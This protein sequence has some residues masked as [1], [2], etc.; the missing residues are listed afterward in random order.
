MS[1]IVVGL[2]HRTAPVEVLERAAVP[3]D[4]LP[5]ALRSLIALEHV[6][7]AAVLST[8]NRVEVYAHLSRFHA[9][10]DELLTWFSDRVDLA[11]DELLG[12]VVY[13]H[14]D[15]AAAQHLFSVAS[16]LDSLIVGERQIA[17]QVKQTLHHAREE[18]TGRRMLQKL[19]NQALGTSRRVRR[20]TE[21][22]RGVSSMVDLG[23]R[24]ASAPLGGLTD[25]TV[26]VV[27]AGKI[28]SLAAKRLVAAGVSRLL[29]HN[30]TPER[31][32]RLA[33]RVDG[34]AVDHDE[35]AGAVAAA[36]LV[37][38]CAGASSPLIRPRVVER[39]V[40]TTERSRPLVLLDLAMPRNVD[41]SCA[42]VDGAVLVDLEQ[43]RAAAV[44]AV[45]STA[46][47]EARAIIEEEVGRFRSWGQAVKVDPTIRALRQR[48]EAVRAEEIERLASRLRHLDE[49][50]RETVEALTRGILNTL[51]HDPTVRLKSL[52][53]A[54]GAEHYAIALRELFDLDE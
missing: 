53:D 44:E 13:A 46:L 10:L 36:D 30:R 5:K 19:F 47:A 52:A 34:E 37:I 38:C 43:V 9:G 54:G 4:D 45:S 2:N 1:V 21:I 15:D 48:A 42:E 7:E 35:L 12:G 25:A 11:P 39:A 17:L 51:L 8:C 28:G 29:V 40:E 24:T 27:G 32:D 31:A 6:V 50:D 41:P 26:L 23:L 3:A 18:G 20:D 22:E 49:R 16:G 33:D 14:F